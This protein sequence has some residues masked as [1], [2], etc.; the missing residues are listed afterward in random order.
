MT[1]IARERR[2]L[3]AAGLVLRTRESW[4]AVQSYTSARDVVEPAQGFVLHISVT[5][6]GGNTGGSEAD[7]MR[8]IEAIGEQRFGIGFPYNAAVFDTGRIYEGQPLTRRGAHT[9]NTKD[10]PGYVQSSSGS[11]NPWYRAIVLPQMVLDDVTDA[12]VDQCARWAAAQVRSGLARRSDYQWLGHRDVAYKSCPGDTGYA[13]L[14]EIRRLTAQY[15]R[16]GLGEEFDMDD[17]H[18]RKLVG[19]GMR[20]AIAVKMGVPQAA[21]NGLRARVA[22]GVQKAVVKGGPSEASIEARVRE[23]VRAEI[24]PRL[25]RIEA[26]LGIDPAPVAASPEIPADDDP[27]D[28]L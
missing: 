1:D 26:A 6:D 16:D 25:A 8:D 21:V 11:M 17:A 5:I 10:A 22:E 18:F 28:E 13:R 15:I 19:E 3:A 12:Q 9:V 4:D 2:L 20:D 14:P 23:G 7:D 24:G 27:D